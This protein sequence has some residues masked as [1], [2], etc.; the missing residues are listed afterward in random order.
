MTQ[1][2]RLVL[3][4]TVVARG[5]VPEIAAAETLTHSI[6]NLDDGVIPVLAAHRFQVEPRA[7]LL[8]STRGRVQLVIPIIYPSL[9]NA[10]LSWYEPGLGGRLHPVLGGPYRFQRYKA[11]LLELVEGCE[12]EGVASLLAPERELLRDLEPDLSLPDLAFV[13]ATRGLEYGPE[14][15]QALVPV[16]QTLRSM[17]AQDSAAPAIQN[18]TVPMMVLEALHLVRV[19]ERLAVVEALA[20][21]SP[22]AADPTFTQALEKTRETVRQRH[23]KRQLVSRQ[24]L[25]SHAA[26]PSLESLGRIALPTLPVALARAAFPELAPEHLAQ[27]AYDHPLALKGPLDV[28]GFQRVETD[29]ILLASL[30][31]E[32]FGG[33]APDCAPADGDDWE[34]LEAT[35]HALGLYAARMYYRTLDSLLAVTGDAFVTGSLQWTLKEIEAGLG[36]RAELQRLVEAR[37]AI[38]DGLL[39]ACDRTRA[40]REPQ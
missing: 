37:R 17:A 28:E 3:I 36:T 4:A 13:L 8:P 34:A 18:G 31:E 29:L 27:L 26:D 23:V 30:D 24:H 12:N 2:Q 20:A 11:V 6:T 15:M 7:D 10:D 1:G 9:S 39:A 38:L 14:F 33:S 35:G 22:I 5:V 25:R 40:D 32:L 16:T 21:S 19:L